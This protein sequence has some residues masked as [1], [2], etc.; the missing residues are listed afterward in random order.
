[1]KSE[2]IKAVYFVGFMFGGLAAR[3]IW[4]AP[5]SEHPWF[6]AILN[7]GAVP[8]SLFLLGLFVA[9]ISYNSLDWS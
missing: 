6:D 2:L 1:M 7:F 3:H 5:A 8:A 9:I 4:S